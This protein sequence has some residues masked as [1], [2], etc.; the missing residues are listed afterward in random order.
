MSR[1]SKLCSS[2]VTSIQ[3]LKGKIPVER[4]TKKLKLSRSTIYRIFDGSY[5]PRPDRPAPP[6][7][8][9][10]MDELTVSTVQ[11]VLAK[12]HLEKLLGR[13]LVVH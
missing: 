13:T 11:F 12:T 10:D 4:L 7:N 3:A 1:I 2:E 6:Q 8:L 5:H 9:Q